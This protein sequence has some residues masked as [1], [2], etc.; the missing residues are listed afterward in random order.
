[1]KAAVV[2]AIGAS[3]EVEDLIIDKPNRREVLVDVRAV[4]L[5]HSDLTFA[6]N[7]FG[8]PLPMV[9][10]HEFSGVVA[11]AGADVTRVAVGDHVVG[12]LVRACGHC[13]DCTAGAPYLCRR[14]NEL[15]RRRSDPPRLR[16]TDGTPVTA[17]LG[18]SAFAQQTLVHEN[19]LVTI[20]DKVPFP[21]AAILG[22]A[23]ITGAGAVINTARVT[24]G[25]SV[26]VVGLGGVGLCAVSGA[27][28]AGATTII[29]V[30]LAREKLEIARRFGATHT[31]DASAED[32]VDAVRKITGGSGV[33]HAF[34]A[35]G[36]PATS[37]QA[38]R[39]TGAGGSA[40]LLGMHK[41]DSAIGLDVTSDLLAYQRSV[42]G[43]YMG[44]SNIWRDIPM[45]ADMYLAG[46][47][48]LDDL[49]ASTISL[50][51]INQGFA[52]MR[53][54]HAARSVVTSWD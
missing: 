12:S 27:Q 54:G 18:T 34:E 47:L 3:F 53:T 16:R 24:P 35:V 15:L 8:T 25:E 41:P 2:S 17:A 14:R 9:L 37:L 48:N 10:G 13:P 45:Y 22:C 43:V 11:E 26:A 30:D 28:I 50:S 49:V 5:C 7:D 33:R 21:Q 42:V 40:Y 20:S 32:P 36:I 19:Q 23:T 38:V 6:E 4:G 31:V 29:A 52:Q 39:M 1:V 46:R 44:S 51:Q